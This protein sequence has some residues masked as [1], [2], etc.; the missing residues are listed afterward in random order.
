MWFPPARR[1]LLAGLR[2]VAVA[3]LCTVA[4]LLAK[5]AMAQ[6]MGDWGTVSTP[7]TSP[8][9]FSFAQYDVKGNF[10][11]DYTFTLEG[12]AD[13]AYSVSL[14]F[15]SCR[16]GCGNPVL[17]YGIGGAL[18]ESPTGT[19]LLVPGTYSFTV[20]GTGMGAGNSVDYWGS[21]VISGAPGGIV[22]P[23]PEPEVFILAVPGLML[24]MAVVRRRK[25]RE[26]TGDS[27]TGGARARPAFSAAPAALLL[28]VPCLLVAAGCSSKGDDTPTQVV[29]KV[30]STEI[31]SLQLELAMKAQ[32]GQMGADADRQQV[33]EKLIDRELA[34]QQAIARKLDRQPEVM[35]RLEELRREILASA[36]AEQVAA[37]RPRPSEQA[38]R[39]FY[40]EHPELFAQRRIYR[41]RELVIPASASQ[42]AQAK[43]RLANRQPLAEVASWLASESAR[44]SQQ[45]VLRA[46][47]QLP[48]EALPKLNRASEGQT[49]TFEA[50]RAIYVYQVLGIQPAPLDLV[51][52]TPLITEHL[53]RRE[54]DRAMRAELG[55]LRAT[56]SIEVAGTP[57]ARPSPVARSGT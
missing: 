57:G 51:A 1:S 25:A 41:L 52:A 40:A 37:A 20:T 36:L 31:S 4:G 32:R 56:T 26:G 2:Q 10:T 54:G 30:G 45:E 3:L 16:N 17:N 19:Y 38:V 44:F 18:S 55:I 29:A 5:P 27:A 28:A 46:A 13:A 15:D 42:L 47:E 34:V 50:P 7:I 22:S 23:V 21:V 53:A 39:T 12:S 14:Q 24:V 48:M 6:V 11:H 33:I 43:E 9:T 49:V 8:V 35:L